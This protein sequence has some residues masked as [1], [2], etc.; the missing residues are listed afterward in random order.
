MVDGRSYIHF[1]DRIGDTFRWKGENVS[2][3]EVALAVAR[4]ESLDE[5]N[6]VGVEVPG[7]D[8]RA[9]LAAVTLKPGAELDVASLLQTAKRH[10]PAYAVPVFVRVLPQQE[11]TGTFKHMKAKYR[12]E[13]IDPA[14]VCRCAASVLLCQCPHPHTPALTDNMYYLTRM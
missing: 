3:T 4:E 2:T 13:G 9:C 7:K 10:L 14:K 11:T 12:A 5:V 6:I 8:G 1:V